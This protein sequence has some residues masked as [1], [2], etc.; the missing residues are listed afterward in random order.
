MRRNHLIAAVVVGLGVGALLWAAPPA[1]SP[2]P[3]KIDKLVE[4]LGSSSFADREKAQTALEAIGAPA[5]PALRKAAKSDDP[6]VRRRAATLLGPLE[7]KAEQAAIL[8]PTKVH[9]VYKDTPLAEAVA[10]F[11]KKAGATIELLDPEGAL[12]DRKVTLDTGE[13]TFWSALEQFCQKAGVKEAGPERLWR[14]PIGAPVPPIGPVPPVPPPPA[15]LPAIKPIKKPVPAPDE[16]GGL[17]AKPAPA[18]APLPPAK[19]VPVPLRAAVAAPMIRASVNFMTFQSGRILLVDGKEPPVSTDAAT[20]FRVQAFPHAGPAGAPLPGDIQLLLQV[21]PEPR[22]RLM[23][24]ESVRVSKAV[25]DAGQSLEHVAPDAPPAGGFAVPGV[26]RPHFRIAG[27]GFGS[28][29]V[30]LKKGDKESKSVE[31]LSGTVTAHVAL[32]ARP[33]VTVEN[34]L[35]ASGKTVKGD[36]GGSIK[37]NAIEEEKEQVTISIALE[38]PKDVMAENNP[39]PTGAGGVIRPLVPKALPRAIPAPVPPPVPLPGLAGALIPP[40][41]AAPP[42]LAPPVMMGGAIALGVATGPFNGLTLQDAKGNVLPVT[43]QVKF[44]GVPGSAM[45]FQ[46][47]FRPEKGLGEPAKLVYTG[48]KVAVA[49]VPFTLKGVKLE[50]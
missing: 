44:N 27:M 4:Q 38:Q 22:L 9:L 24:V 47:V 12:K 15:P 33:F 13:T 40:A 43:I 18:A 42:P 37:V 29:F 10:D 34:I 30:G 46:I 2:N 21:T 7:H 11:A 5:L 8:A 50:K 36:A 19:P 16:D 14:A 41:I 39:Y 20:A 28:I 49:E 6:E 26:V 32:D 48:R 35:K 17:A 45:D 25:D 3:E 23:G 31:A 1:E